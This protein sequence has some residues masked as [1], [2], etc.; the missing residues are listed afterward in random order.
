M[1]GPSSSVGC[2]S[3]WSADGRGFDPPV[4]QYSFVEI[5]HEIIYTAI[6]PSRW[7]K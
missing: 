6:L 4:R 3:A 2:A 7:F 1:T 5:G